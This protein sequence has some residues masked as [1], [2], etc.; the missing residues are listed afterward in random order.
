[1]Q[2]QL[3]QGFSA[4]GK[5]ITAMAFADD[6]VLVSGSWNGMVANIGILETFCKLAE[7]R[8]QPSK[9]H[10][11]FIETV[12]RSLVVNNC[13]RWLLAGSALHFIGPGEEVSSDS[14]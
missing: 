1:M 8:V 7:M 13:P 14:G 12:E 5:S 9:C 10:G 11:F 3:D 4:G 2:N 6:L